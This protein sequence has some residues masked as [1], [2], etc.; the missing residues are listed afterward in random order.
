M[1]LI[2]LIRDIKRV[3]DLEGHFVTR[4]GKPTTYYIDK[5]LFQTNPKILDPLADALAGL[6]P[7]PDTYDRIG[8]PELGAVPIGALLSVK[9]NK[10]FVIVK[11]QAKDYGTSRQ[12]E[13]PYFPGERIVVVE[14]ILTTGGAV[15]NACNALVSASLNV[16]EIIGII[17]REEGAFENLAAAGFP[18]VKALMT[19]T[20]LQSC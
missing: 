18:H 15:L 17:N 5:Y 13:G 4:S 14:D 8:A 16:V 20:D 7:S 19:R 9:L 11:K 10:P 12:I 3:A 1:A 2:D 6:F